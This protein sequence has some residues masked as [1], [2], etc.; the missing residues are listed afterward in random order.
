MRLSH[1]NRQADSQKGYHFR[2]STLIKE[3]ALQ[4]DVITT[5]IKK[6]NLGLEECSYI[7]DHFTTEEVVT[8]NPDSKRRVLL[9]YKV[10]VYPTEQFQKEQYRLNTH[11]KHVQTYKTTSEG[12]TMIRPMRDQYKG[13]DAY[14]KYLKDKAL[15]ESLPT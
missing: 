1:R 12:Q 13:S 8:V 15:F 11:Q 10:S 4:K 14:G 3:G 7:I 9:D 5:N 2:L 6:I